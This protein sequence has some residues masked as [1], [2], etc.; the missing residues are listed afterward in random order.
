V[1]K[2]ILR[3]TVAGLA[4]LALGACKFTQS[5]AVSRDA[6]E[7]QA[8]PTAQTETQTQTDAD[9]SDETV[10]SGQDGQ[11][12]ETQPADPDAAAK[13]ARER[14]R[15]LARLRRDMEA[16]Q[17][18]LAKA[19]TNEQN[20]ELKHQEAL[21]SANVEM[22]LAKRRLEAFNKFTAPKRVARAE[23]DLQ[24]A[25]DRHLE[26]REELQQLELMYK[27]EQ[28][29]D[30]TKEIVIERARRRLARSTRDL[31]LRRREFKTLTDVTLPMEQR[32][33]EHKAEQKKRAALN[34]QRDNEGALLDRKIA[35]INAESAVVKLENQLAD[36]TE[37]IE[38]AQ[39]EKTAAADR[40]AEAA[41]GPG[42]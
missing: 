2:N 34:V 11:P 26:A 28:F 20:G 10:S 15:K 18:K 42:Q 21:A 27:D 12:A 4:L 14:E 23:L 31:E 29:A 30:Q 37:E 9:K 5:T 35:V 19:H 41:A 39:R 16:A 22:E 6:G 32:E 1:T 33:L 17:L 3:F 25:E 40:P 13:E 7:P 24:R 8:V 38:K 36:L